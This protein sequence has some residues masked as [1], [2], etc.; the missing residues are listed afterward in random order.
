MG[1]PE[2][3]FFWLVIFFVRPQRQTVS[4]FVSAVVIMEKIGNAVVRACLAVAFSMLLTGSIMADQPREQGFNIPQQPVQ[5]AL[6]SLATQAN[7]LLLFPYDPVTDMDANPVVGNYSIQR[8]LDLLLRNTGLRGDLTG[9]GV[10]AIS[11]AG[12]DAS[13]TMDISKGKRMNINKRKS[14]LATL[15]GVVAAGGSGLLHAQDDGGDELGWLLEEVVVTATRRETS[16]QDTAMAI[17]AFSGKELSKK[18][19][20]SFRDILTSVPGVSIGNSD[21]TNTKINIRGVQGGDR[22]NNIGATNL[23]TLNDF[24]IGEGMENIMLVDMDRVEVLKGPQGTLYGKSSMGGT[25]RYITKKPNTDSLTA[26]IETMVSST[27]LGGLNYGLEGHVNLPITDNIAVRMVGYDY[28]HDGFIDIVGLDKKSNANTKDIEGIRASI[29]WEATDDLMF[30][31][32]Y[33]DQTLQTGTAQRISTTY[34]PFTSPAFSSV[35]PSNAKDPSFSN[36]A[37][38]Y[39]EPWGIDNEALMVKMALDFDQFELSVMGM[40]DETDL[41]SDFE[42]NEYILI[43]DGSG[44]VVE[45]KQIKS[46]KYE[47]RLVSNSEED[48]FFDW[49]L[50]FWYE[51]SDGFKTSNVTYRED[52]GTGTSSNGVVFDGDV[53]SDSREALTSSEK[54]IYGEVGM[55]LTDKAKLTLGYRKADVEA[56]FI[57]QV[58]ARGLFNIKDKKYIKQQEYA[59]TYKANFEYSLSDNILLY[60]LASSGYRAGGSNN[61]TALVGS[62]AAP[63]GYDSDSLWN[64]ELGAKTTWID[65]RLIINANFYRI[66]WSDLQTRVLIIDEDISDGNDTFSGIANVNSADITGF[67]LESRYSISEN[68]HVG[69]SFTY[70]DTQL[71]EDDPVSGAKSGDP[72]AEVPDRTI[73]LNL[74]WV[75]PINDDYEASVFATYRYIGEYEN[76][77]GATQG[78]AVNVTNSDYST[79]DLN[80]TVAHA[81]SGLRASLFANNLFNK[82]V[83]ETTFNINSYF[84]VQH[85]NSPRTV[86]LKVGYDF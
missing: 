58:Y 22:V 76:W 80:I 49:I 9:G 79:T 42:L 68:L 74:D 20:L 18:S 81:R 77:L 23:T 78:T 5:S 39:L 12:T 53:L 1:F 73:A 3:F 54:A 72:L 83:G 51:D 30:E 10:I 31:M 45:N 57:T 2:D 44:S 34:T 24:P 52:S 27:E 40:R 38:Q 7:M 64:Y 13:S 63:A 8:A 14:L 71:N 15:V 4:R 70:M 59:E 41:N 61:N 46:N 65:D 67:E 66:D 75:Y 86:G 48:D 36:P 84:T 29:I 56:P 25:I 6:N 11:Q 17:S 55:Q 43:T 37:N 69:L 19:H 33:I 26:G 50:G 47:I 82:I 32:M 16:L 35:A 28:S 62:G 85:I 60:T 21:P